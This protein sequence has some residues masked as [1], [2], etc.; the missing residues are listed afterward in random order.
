MNSQGTTMVLI[1][2]PPVIRKPITDPSEM[3]KAELLANESLSLEEKQNPSNRFKR[4]WGLYMTGQYEAALD[5]FEFLLVASDVSEATDVNRKDVELFHLLTLARLKRTSEVETAFSKWQ[6]N[7]P[8]SFSDI[9][10]SVVPLWLGQKEE[11]VLRLQNGLAMADRTDYSRI[12]YLAVA[13]ALF[14]VHESATSGEKEAWTKQALDLFRDLPRNFVIQKIRID[15]DLFIL[16][17]EPEF[18]EMASERPNLP[19]NPYWIANREV[20]RGEFEAFLRDTNFNGPKP[21]KWSVNEEVSPTTAHPVQQVSWFD[22]I[23]FCNWL[24]AKEGR[25][26]AYRLNGKE[27]IKNYD[28]EEVEID[29]WEEVAESDGYR[30]PKE[31]E[32]DFAC[33]AGTLTNWS[34]GNDESLLADYCQMF[35]SKL[36]ALGGSKL[37]N[38]W[39]LHEMHGNLWEWC[40]DLYDAGY[41]SS[42]V[43]RGGCWNNVASDCE[44]SDRFRD[45]PTFRYDYF[46]FRVALSP[47]RKTGDSESESR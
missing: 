11:A 7:S 35:P 29:K 38:A 44:S 14:A 3:I 27:K 24:S 26:P 15:P 45:P 25:M 19:N 40:W 42:R 37:P 5:E 20:T 32:W 6:T 39:G 8:K 47:S 18:L 17:V 16:H 41:S 23:Q 28:D 10:E 13:S 1:T 30:L 2:P 34:P 33:R 43:N 4:G 31:L 46:G 36:T 22:A 9:V 21:E 12:Y